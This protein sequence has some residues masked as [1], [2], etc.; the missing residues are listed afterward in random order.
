MLADELT[1]AGELRKRSCCLEDLSRVQ[2]YLTRCVWRILQDIAVPG[3]GVFEIVIWVH[4]EV[5]AFGVPLLLHHVLFQRILD[6]LLVHVH[7]AS[8]RGHVGGQLEFLD[9]L[10]LYYLLSIERLHLQVHRL[11]CLLFITLFHLVQLGMRQLAPVHKQLDLAVQIVQLCLDVWSKKTFTVDIIE[12][13]HLLH[14]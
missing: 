6:D 8:P 3:G 7:H 5:D 11:L 12:E 10:G 14:L 2:L 1:I 9:L 13:F 4:G